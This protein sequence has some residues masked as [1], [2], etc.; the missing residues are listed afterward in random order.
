MATSSMWDP[1][2]GPHHHVMRGPTSGP[3]WPRHPS[4]TRWW[5]HGA[6]SSMLGPAGVTA[7]PHHRG[8]DPLVG[9]FATSLRSDP[10][11][12]TTAPH[13][14]GGILAKHSMMIK[15]CCSMTFLLFSS[16]FFMPKLR[17]LSLMTKLSFSS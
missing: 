3:A 2:V 8:R 14:R 9:C 11:G 17:H 7:C 1:L 15:F 6:T 10:L 16:L 4:G 12:G 5:D 13:T